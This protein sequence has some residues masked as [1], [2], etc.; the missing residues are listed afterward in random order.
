[1][2]PEIKR[3]SAASADLPESETNL[4]MVLALVH[5]VLPQLGDPDKAGEVQAALRKA[6][7][8]VEAARDAHA[9]ET[10]VTA[11]NAAHEGVEAETVAVIAAAIS[12]TLGRP[13]RLVSV[14]PTAVLVPHFNVW[15]LEGRTQIFSSHRLR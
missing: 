4:G 7:A 5:H 8:Y 11:G 15:A 13:Y 12:A 2:S 9:H 3:L 6:C 14:Q 1:M 10:G